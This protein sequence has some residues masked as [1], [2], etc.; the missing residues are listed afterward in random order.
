MQPSLHWMLFYNAISHQ[1]LSCVAIT[2]LINTYEIE[3]CN[4]LFIECP[5]DNAISDQSLSCV[6]IT[7]L[8][9]TYDI[10]LCNVLLMAN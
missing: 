6:G 2:R 10:E 5:F 7:R 3:L 9:N 4:H 1:S 8:I